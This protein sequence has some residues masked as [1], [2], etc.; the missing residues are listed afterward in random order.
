MPKNDNFDYE[1]G[2]KTLKDTLESADKLSS[3]F[4][5]MLEKS[6]PACNKI[7]DIIKVQ[8]EELYKSKKESEKSSKYDRIMKILTFIG[9][10]VATGIVSI[11]V[12]YFSK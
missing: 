9:G 11:I 3:H 12:N 10:C 7:I 8:F 4:I 5:N 1:E 6:K 2:F